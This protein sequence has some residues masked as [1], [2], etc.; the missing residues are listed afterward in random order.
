MSKRYGQFGHLLKNLRKQAGLTQS[1]LLIELGEETSLYGSSTVSKWENGYQLPRD[2]HIEALAEIL[3]AP[4]ETLFR[5][6]HRPD[7]AD[8]SR[9]IANKEGEAT[10]KKESSVSGSLKQVA[11]EHSQGQLGL[12]PV[13]P[14]AQDK[15]LTDRELPREER[16]RA[17]AHD[18]GIFKESDAILSE[19][20]VG[21]IYYTL[22]CNEIDDDRHIKLG[23]FLWF[24]SY[25]GNK[26]VAP[27]VREKCE[28]F[29]KS[30]DEVCRFV[31]EHFHGMETMPGSPGKS[32]LWIP[33][34]HRWKFQWEEETWREYHNLEPELH[35]LA[36]KM[37]EAYKSY[38]ATVRETLI[39]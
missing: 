11:E 5:A 19:T 27:T 31:D 21:R 30:S 8:Y 1:Q 16:K 13:I 33:S 34:P 26:F 17:I 12:E 7:K 24:L 10:L 36:T 9:M 20:D 14:K 28:Q 35:R 39:I 23:E 32:E 18:V 29:M 15:H 6:A 38:R 4:K 3:H 2:A 37:L 22:S 25:E